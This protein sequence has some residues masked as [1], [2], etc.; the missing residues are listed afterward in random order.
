ME[1]QSP[2]GTQSGATRDAVCPEHGTY[3]AKLVF[4][5]RW[6][7]CFACQAQRD[8]QA[9]EAERAEKNRRALE[10]QNARMAES[11][12]EPRFIKATFENFSATS[13]KQVAARTACRGF[14]DGLATG[15]SGGLW[16]VGP[17]GTGKTHLGSAMVNHVIC[18]QKAWAAIHSG[19]AIVRLL[20]AGWGARDSHQQELET[21]EKLASMSLLVIDEAGIGFGSDAEMVQLFDVID[22]RY[23]KE[24]PTVVI[25]NLAVKDLKPVLGDAAFDRLREDATIVPCN[26]PSHRAEPRI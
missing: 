7:G 16:L 22:L 15:G 2:D 1:K 13:P 17:P 12:L 21:L 18:E 3:T 4:G 23:R 20:R 9:A 5:T 11:G 25:S 8:E 14:V 10:R 6:T 24:L 19:R 26:W